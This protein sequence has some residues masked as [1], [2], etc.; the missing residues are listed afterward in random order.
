MKSELIRILTERKKKDTVN[1]RT[2]LM[3]P[4]SGPRVILIVTVMSY[5]V[6]IINNKF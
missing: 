6:G 5:Y 4:D 3:P 1:G 2:K